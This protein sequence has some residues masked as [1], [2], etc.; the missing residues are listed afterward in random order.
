MSRPFC[1]LPPE[2]GTMNPILIGVCGVLVCALMIVAARDQR[3]HQQRRLESVA[4]TRALR[5]SEVP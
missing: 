2:S 5:L 3:E 1:A 4:T